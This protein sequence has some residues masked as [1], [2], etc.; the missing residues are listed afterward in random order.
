[1]TPLI[2]NFRP[3]LL[4]EDHTRGLALVGCRAALNLGFAVL[5]RSWRNG[6]DSDLCTGI[7]K[8]TLDALRALPVASV[9]DESTISPI[10]L[11][12]VEKSESFLQSV[13]IGYF[14]KY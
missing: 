1:M 14:I 13:A 6:E 7:L 10:W 5:R 9:F 12:A 3:T 11:E 2:L 8:E 4:P